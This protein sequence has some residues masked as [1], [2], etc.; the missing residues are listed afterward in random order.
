MRT[1]TKRAARPLHSLDRARAIPTTPEFKAAVARVDA[2]LR[3]GTARADKQKIERALARWDDRGIDLSILAN[4]IDNMVMRAGDEA[5]IRDCGSDA[6][7]AMGDAA[8]IYHALRGSLRRAIRWCRKYDSESVEGFVRLQRLIDSSPIAKAEDIWKNR[9]EGR[10][11]GNRDLVRQHALKT[12]LLTIAV[13]SRGTFAP[14][15][16]AFTQDQATLFA[17]VLENRCSPLPVAD[18]GDSP[19]FR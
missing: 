9:P 19:T 16:R 18:H 12:A 17:R 1:P 6:S 8:T 7:E 10:G 3:P 15:K 5:K 13:P 14:H 11:R 4:L 2:L